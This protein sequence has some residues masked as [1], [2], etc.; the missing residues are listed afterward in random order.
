MFYGRQCHHAQ[1]SVLN[2]YNP[3]KVRVNHLLDG[4]YHGTHIKL[5]ENNLQGSR[6]IRYGGYGGIAY[7]Q[8]AD[9][10]IILFTSFVP[11]GV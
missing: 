3:R 5:R 2:R 7:Y 1:T 8:V 4:R 11:C 9:N 10:Y 6:H